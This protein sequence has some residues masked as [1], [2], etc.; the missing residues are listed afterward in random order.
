MA[1][2]PG[3]PSFVAGSGPEPPDFNNLIQAPLLFCTAKTVLR[4]AQPTGGQSVS[5]GGYTSPVQFTQVLEDP[6]SGWSAVATGSQPA[7]SYLVPYDGWYDITLVI[8]CGNVTG[9]LEPAIEI[10]NTTTFELAAV[11]VGGSTPPISTGSVKAGL[12]GGL[13]YVTARIASSVAAT[14]SGSAP[15]RN[16]A[17]EIVYT[18]E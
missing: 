10:S 16:C 2:P 6:Y 8:A 14:T 1:A 12:I 15:G 9:H 7:Y 3:P 11:A 17:M 18:G 4:V 5:G 13:D